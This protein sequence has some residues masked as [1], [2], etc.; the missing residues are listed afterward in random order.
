MRDKNS[1]NNNE[2]KIEVER[3]KH[4]TKKNMDDWGEIELGHRRKEK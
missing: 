1:N 2:K 4:V 3:E